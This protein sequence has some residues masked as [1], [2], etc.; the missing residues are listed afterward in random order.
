[1][2]CIPAPPPTPANGFTPL[3]SHPW[4]GHPAEAAYEDALLFAP[5]RLRMTGH[6]QG[7]NDIRGCQLVIPFFSPS[8]AP[9]PASSTLYARRFV[10]LSFT[11]ERNA[12]ENLT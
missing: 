7:H 5:S 9:S 12:S 4:H 3:S 11:L 10:F 1:M 8:S 6:G 2:M